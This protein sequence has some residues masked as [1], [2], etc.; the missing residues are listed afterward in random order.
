M[1]ETSTAFKSKIL[2]I[3]FILFNTFCLLINGVIL[4]WAICTDNRVDVNIYFTLVAY[5]FSGKWAIWSV[6]VIALS[7]ITLMY[8]YFKKVK[9]LLFLGVVNIFLSPVSFLVYAG[10]H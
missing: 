2:F 9:S 7:T 5:F 3:S 10:T 4:I 8:A 6:C 1:R